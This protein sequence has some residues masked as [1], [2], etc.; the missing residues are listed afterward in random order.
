MME[1]AMS[2]GTANSSQT[3]A[4]RW[5]FFWYPETNARPWA[6]QVER[7]AN[8]MAMLLPNNTD[9]KDALAMARANGMP[10]GS[11]RSGCFEVQNDNGIWQRE[12]AGRMDFS[13]PRKAAKV[14]FTSWDELEAKEL[15]G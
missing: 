11:Q 13:T 10:K 3:T 15:A 7:G 1:V 12:G 8:R 2:T 14:R 4:G 9:I 5:D 6:E